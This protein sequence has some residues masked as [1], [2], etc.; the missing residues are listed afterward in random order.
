MKRTAG[1]PCSSRYLAGITVILAGIL[2][3]LLLGCA[4]KPGVPPEMSVWDVDFPPHK[5]I[6]NVHFVGRKN[7]GIF[8][9]TTAEGHVLIDSGFEA[10]V[11]DIKASV[12]KLGFRFEDIKYLLAS[13]AHVDHVQGHARVRQLTGAKVLAS[14][15]DAPFIASGGKDD[16]YFENRYR[17]TACP[18][19]KIVGDGDKVEIGGT[20]LT[21]R[22]T[23]GHTPG[24]TTWTMDVED[25]GQRQAVVFFPSGNI[26]PGTKLVGNARYPHIADDLQ[27]SFAVW[28]ALRCDVFLGAHGVFYDLG[29]KHRQL[30]NGAPAPG[31]PNPFIDREG[32]PRVVGDL[33][34]R[35]Q[36]L[37]DD[38]R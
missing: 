36:A 9:I 20:T 30:V 2:A 3:G 27:R 5:V 26:L 18:V 38:Q 16:T 11:P 35:F 8:L 37:L 6:G 7:I 17:W 25:G 28:K 13:H 34:T 24:A 29:R 22:L 12:E 14:E 15:P 10:S 21:A 32:L 19:D 31:K 1:T 23:P 33:E 4:G